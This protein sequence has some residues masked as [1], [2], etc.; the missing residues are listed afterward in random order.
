MDN[1]ELEELKYGHLHMQE[2]SQPKSRYPMTKSAG[3]Q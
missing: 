1:P 3:D 2:D